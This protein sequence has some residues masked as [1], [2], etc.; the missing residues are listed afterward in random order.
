MRWRLA[1]FRVESPVLNF[2]LLNSSGAGSQRTTV[3]FCVRLTL[4]NVVRLLE[5]V[6]AWRSRWGKFTNFVREANRFGRWLQS[7]TSL[8]QVV[9]TWWTKP[10]F[11][12]TLTQLSLASSLVS[13]S[14]SCAWPC[15][16]RRVPWCNS[17][18]ARLS[19]VTFLRASR[20]CEHG[21]RGPHPVLKFFEANFSVT[22]HI[23]PPQN[24]Q[25]LSLCCHMPLAFHKSLEICFVQVAVIPVIYRCESFFKRKVI[26]I[27]QSSFKLIWLEMVPN[28]LKQQLTQGPLNPHRE[29]LASRHVSSRPLRGCC[30]KVTVIT[31]Q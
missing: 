2:W 31:R 30:S 18:V 3:V 23:K 5:L 14:I 29:E 27:L 1:W 13:F 4:I 10:L 20:R 16:L 19:W 12:S 22:I 28:L 8:T 11:A 9:V 15:N 7:G 26:C 17:F 24:S 6:F 25:N 21:Q